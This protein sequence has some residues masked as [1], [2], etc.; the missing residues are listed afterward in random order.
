MLLRIA[1][2][3]AI[4]Q[5]EKGEHASSRI[6]SLSVAALLREL[7]EGLRIVIRDSHLRT[8]LVVSGAQMLVGYIWFAVDIF[9]VQDSLGAPK[10]NVGILWA[11]SGIGGLIGGML[12]TTAS[13]RLTRRAMLLLGL[14]MRSGALVWYSL[15][16]VF[17]WAIPAAAVAGMGD[18]FVFVA[19]G[20]LQMECSPRAALG[21][22]TSL[23]ETTSQA[24]SLAAIVALGL[25]ETA[26]R[27][28]QIL[29]A[30]AIALAC[31]LVV[32][33]AGLRD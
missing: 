10:G 2:P 17:V 30:C 13:N 9:F 14:G 28:W 4:P 20:T 32:A 22:V 18:A 6:P 12:V 11:A 3:K 25:L 33:G 26:L 19:V 23:F 15:M 24:F 7:G 31:T 16:H 29:L 5:A 8:A 21:R 27:P 1:L